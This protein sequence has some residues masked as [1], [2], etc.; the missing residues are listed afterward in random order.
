M[1]EMRVCNVTEGSPASDKKQ[2]PS[3]SS[4]TPLGAAEDGPGCRM[5]KR[6]FNRPNNINA[7]RTT[8]AQFDY[9]PPPNPSPALK[10]EFECQTKRQFR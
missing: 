3:M 7:P 2:G 1:Q 4:A 6:S 9:A 5:R 8:F 10:S